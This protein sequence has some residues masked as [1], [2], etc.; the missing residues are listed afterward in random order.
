[1]QELTDF[2]MR[3][4]ERE[5]VTKKVRNTFVIGV[6]MLKSKRNEPTIQ[7]PVVNNSQ[8][9]AAIPRT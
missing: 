1:M 6:T 9:I 3:P 5:A 7:W 2:E 8:M 4:F